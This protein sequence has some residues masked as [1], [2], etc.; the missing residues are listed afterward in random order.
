[1]IPFKSMLKTFSDALGSSAGNKRSTSGLHARAAGY[2]DT[3][4]SPWGDGV[5]IFEY[6]LPMKAQFPPHQDPSR[7]KAFCAITTAMA[8]QSEL[9]AADMRIT[10]FWLLIFITRR[11]QL[12]HQAAVGLWIQLIAGDRKS[13][14]IHWGMWEDQDSQYPHDAVLRDGAYLDA[15]WSAAAW[16]EPSDWVNLQ[17][18]L[19]RRLATGRFDDDVVIP[20]PERPMQFWT[21]QD[22]VLRVLWC[23]IN[24]I[25]T[26]GGFQSRISTWRS[27]SQPF[28]PKTSILP[29]HSGKDPR[30]IGCVFDTMEYDEGLWLWCQTAALDYVE[31]PEGPSKQRS[32]R[33]NAT[34]VMSVLGCCHNCLVRA[35]NANGIFLQPSFL[36]SAA[37]WPMIIWIVYQASDGSAKTVEA[38][39]TIFT[40]NDAQYDGLWN[41]DRD[42]QASLS[43]VFGTPVALASRWSHKLPVWEWLEQVTPE[44]WKTL[45]EVTVCT[46]RARRHTTVYDTTIRVAALLLW[47]SK[48]GSVT[49]GLQAL[50]DMLEVVNSEHALALHSVLIP[51][52]VDPQKNFD[53]RMEMT[54]NWQNPGEWLLEDTNIL[55]KHLL[56]NSQ[57][58]LIPYKYVAEL[59]YAIGKTLP[60]SL[61]THACTVFLLP[62]PPTL[63]SLE[64]HHIDLQTHRLWNQVIQLA[65]FWCS[66]DQV[67]RL[68][69]FQMVMS[70]LLELLGKHQSNVIKTVNKAIIHSDILRASAEIVNTL[71]N[72]DTYTYFMDTQDEKAQKL[73]DLLQDMLDYPL[74]D[75]AV[76]P[77]MLKALLK[78][79]SKS[80]RHP[81][82]FVL[83]DRLRLLGNQ[84]AAGS[85]G[86]VWKGTFRGETVSVKV[87]RVYEEGDTAALIKGF[88]QEA[89]IWRQLNH[90][91][92]LPF[93][94]VYYLEDARTR[95]CLISPWMESGNIARYLKTNP[96]N[97]N[98]TSLLTRCFSPLQAQAHGFR[99]VLDVALGLEYL[100][101]LKLVHGDL[102]AVN[103]LV[104]ASGQAVLADFGLSTITDSK[105]LMST[106]TAKVG[107]TVRWQAP[108]LFHAAPNSRASDIY[109]YGCVCYEIFTGRV[110]FWEVT[111]DVAVMFKVMKNIRPTQMREIPVQ[112]WAL[113]IRCWAEEAESRPT[114]HAVISTL[115]DGALA[116]V[117]T[118]DT[119]EW[120]A[121]YVT[122]FRASL[123]EHALFLS[124]G[125]AD[126]IQF[127]DERKA[128]AQNGVPL[129]P[130]KPYEDSMRRVEILQE[131]IN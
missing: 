25:H 121:L 83:S 84:I 87:M 6:D 19:G 114:I 68:A 82:C 131:G 62:D 17:N 28:W 85:Y 130:S 86:D 73:L 118:S 71:Q 39:L 64:N 67:T 89:L 57:A 45:E 32:L 40:S 122:R 12:G 107:G 128:K 4:F 120:D 38:L 81:R 109:A 102:K 112:I 47:A 90:P 42:D 125:S 8:T 78:L 74:V 22:R 110:P 97:I 10:L 106:S 101:Q 77:I 70:M 98:R 76:R 60:A 49:S 103:I 35:I 44:D 3:S 33:P 15:L 108:E 13:G 50:F 52:A 41:W 113:M 116:A 93:L 123:E 80:G 65:N 96:P 92:L 51:G 117:P 79:S 55:Q 104:S 36:S 72:I 115:R 61:L 48:F 5:S 24:D 20:I 58:T 59:V 14:W 100:H 34:V 21:I 94:G 11:P 23:T 111:N 66:W 29:V 56:Q 2:G 88:Y 129:N 69:N 30:D 91:N 16:L 18:S 26:D 95:L 9:W 75:D 99:K 127:L 124:Y 37:L 63:P 53:N 54:V 27:V 126:W 119:S 46:S 31:K 7:N 105:F 43:A 1:M